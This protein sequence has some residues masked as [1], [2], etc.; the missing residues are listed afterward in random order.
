MS[1]TSHFP[2]MLLN[3]NEIYS[4]NIPV[5]IETDYYVRIPL[6]DIHFANLCIV[7]A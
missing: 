7:M 6:F 5:E 4:L 1:I 3:I 2:Y